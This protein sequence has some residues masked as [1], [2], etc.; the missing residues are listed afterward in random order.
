MSRTSKSTTKPSAVPAALLAK[1]SRPKGTLI[2]GGVLLVLLV[3]AYTLVPDLP[4]FAHLLLALVFSIV[5]AVTVVFGFAEHGRKL[6]RV[7]LPQI[8]KFDVDPVPPGVVAGVVVFLL[9]FIWWLTPLA[10]VRVLSASAEELTALFADEMAHVVLSLSEERLAAAEYPMLPAGAVYAA[11]TIPD[12][13]DLYRLSL[14]SLARGEF[15]AALDQIEEAKQAGDVDDRQY[16]LA[17][18]Q[19]RAFQGDM[20]AAIKELT[21]ARGAGDDQRQRDR[22]LAALHLYLG[23]GDVAEAEKLSRA[24]YEASAQGADRIEAINLLTAVYLTQGKRR[25]ARQLYGDLKDLPPAS[26]NNQAVVQLGLDMN[27]PAQLNLNQA[28]SAWAQQRWRGTVVPETG[29]ATTVA[30]NQ[31]MRAFIAGQFDRAERELKSVLN[32]K[33]DAKRSRLRADHPSIGVSHTALALVYFTQGRYQKAQE[34]VDQAQGYFKVGNPHRLSGAV[35][36]AR[37][38]AARGDYQRAEF[39]LRAHLVQVKNLSPNHPM[40]AL[41]LEQLATIDLRRGTNLDRAAGR[42]RQALA[43]YGSLN[44][45]PQRGEIAPIMTTLAAIHVKR[46]N[47]AAAE[48]LLD[49]VLAE[50]RG[51]AKR[52]KLFGENHPAIAEL[53]AVYGAKLKAPARYK[54]AIKLLEESSLGSDPQG[55]EKKTWGESH[56]TKAR[57]LYEQA[58]I[59]TRS[60]DLGFADKSF[61]DAL[62]IYDDKTKLL[63]RHPLRAA[64]K[65]GLAVLLRRGNPNSPEAAE[66]DREAA[67]ILPP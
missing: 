28:A 35:L 36:S 52:S 19:I 44:Q 66:L 1:R 38:T 48:P 51:N 7:K 17:R 3:A 43:M 11:E 31:A 39:A 10:P 40:A 50:I 63:D 49:A 58:V 30:H 5:A 23:G 13:A 57:Y 21:E 62:K 53:E 24:L 29:H 32:T 41:I 12:D 65:R 56:P 2:T 9:T 4:W 16:H 34:E 20:E 15:Q 18:G 47:N 8:G 54:L 25:E 64:A 55:A 46:G 37:I 14:R 27:S 42:C 26:F 61:R 59:Y 45:D 6:K 67:E 22:Q 60:N 33:L